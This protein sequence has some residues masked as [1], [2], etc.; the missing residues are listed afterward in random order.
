MKITISFLDETKALNKLYKSMGL[1]DKSVNAISRAI[2]ILCGTMNVRRATS[3]H[4]RFDKKKKKN[5]KS[6]LL[7]SI[8]IKQ[9]SVI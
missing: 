3:G 9:K 4:K 6:V 2:V 7:N 8:K 5:D 1:S